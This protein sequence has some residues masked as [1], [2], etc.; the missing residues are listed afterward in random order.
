MGVYLLAQG[1]NLA[2]AATAAYPVKG[3]FIELGKIAWQ[4]GED[5]SGS[6][7]EP[8]AVRAALERQAD[9]FSV[10]FFLGTDE[11]KDA[12]EAALRE[13]CARLARTEGTTLVWG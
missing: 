9:K 2:S 1:P 4:I 10:G 7:T 3:S 11:Q 5:Y 8:A 6:I 12:C 13:V